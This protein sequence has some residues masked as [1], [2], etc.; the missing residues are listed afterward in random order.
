MFFTKKKQLKK[1][2]TPRLKIIFLDVDGVLNDEKFFLEKAR[3]VIP[4]DE[5]KLLLLKKITDATGAK[6]VLSS[7]WRKLPAEHPDLIKLGEEFQESG[8]EL[9]DMTPV[10]PIN[11]EGQ[12]ERWLR[13]NDDVKK[14]I[15]IDD[16]DVFDDL[17]PYLIKTEWKG[18]NGGGLQEHHVQAAIHMLGRK[19]GK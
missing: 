12:I 16:E 10:L 17:K 6:V 5:G 7:A 1:K 8:I 2:K 4:I 9:Y 13:A 3:D 11:R 15:I 18:E 19:I 14:F